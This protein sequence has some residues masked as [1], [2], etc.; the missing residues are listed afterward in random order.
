L[1]PNVFTQRFNP[2]SASSAANSR[3]DLLYSGAR[4]PEDPGN[5]NSTL[6]DPLSKQG[7]G[8]PYEQ[9]DRGTDTRP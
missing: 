4:S 3:A 5:S 6:V 8:R 9:S 7:P 1:D 2:N